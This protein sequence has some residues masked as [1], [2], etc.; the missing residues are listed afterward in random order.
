WGASGAGV[1][2]EGM[3][4]E[5]EKKYLVMALQKADGLKREAAKLVNMSFRSFRY[6]VKK[7]GIEDQE[8]DDD[9]E[10]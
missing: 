2:L 9:E 4:T 10:V 6:K 3:L 7:Y 1:D 5:M 8:K